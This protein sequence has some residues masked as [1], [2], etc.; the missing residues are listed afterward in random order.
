VTVSIRARIALFGAAVVALTVLLF[1]LVVY[2]PVER[3]LWAQQDQELVQRSTFQ[4]TRAELA[5]FRGGPLGPRLPVDLKKSPES[6]TEILDPSGTPVFATALLDNEYPSIPGNVL[7]QTAPDRG[8]FGEVSEHGTALRIYVRQVRSLPDFALAGYLVTGRPVTGIA[9]LLATLRIFLVLGALL[10]L[11]AA[12]AATWLVAGRALKPLIS[13]ASAAEEIGRTQDLSRRLPEHK[14]DDEVGRLTASFNHM[15]QQLQDAYSR[16][17]GALAAQRRFVADASHE[18]RTPLTT[19]RSNA[20]LML[21]REDITAED[22]HAALQDIADE[23]ERMSRLVQ[24]LLMLARADAGYHLDRAP[25]DVRPIVQDVCRQAQRLHPTRGLE[26]TDTA[27]AS[28]NGNSDALKQ[29][30]WILVDNAVKF[31]PEGGHVRMALT[32]QNG[33][34]HLTVAD[35]GPGI[36]EAD[37]ERIFQRFYQA[38]PARSNDGSGLGLAIAQWIAVEHGGTISARNG[39][40]GAVFEVELPTS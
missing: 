40:R 28:I 6:F 13:M 22:R 32:T 8:Q 9:N 18:L 11:L 36:P 38:D 2:F 29:L 15:L 34:V 1:G 30:V 3:Q 21:K 4:A 24:D 16:L 27:A 25:L 26:L 23:S 5:L 7:S 33:H 37:R 14:P 17:Q 20:G 12:L 10:S 35:E 39:E 19:I 31:T